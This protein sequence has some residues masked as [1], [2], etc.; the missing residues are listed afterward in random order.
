[1]VVED[2]YDSEYR[3]DIKPVPTLYGLEDTGSVI[4][5]GTVSKTLSPAL[6]IGYLV[7]PPA[8]ATV[9]A[10][11]KQL[12]D[13]H[14]PLL[15]QEAFAFLLESGGY[16]A[17]IRRIRR[18]NGERRAALLHALRSRFGETV[19]IEGADAGL[20]VVVWF[21]DLA[22]AMEAVLVAEAGR[23]GLGLHGVSPLYDADAPPGGTERPGPV[24]PGL[25]M[26]YAGLDTGRIARGID[27]LAD[28][29]A[30][31]RRG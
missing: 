14:A 13:R 3:Y 22:P 10:T 17:H 24:H 30:G 18:H 16:E 2:D 9:F 25:V 27:R 4:Y 6:R 20:H 11:A 26:G 15:A 5:L 1:M 7:L 21:R 28:L 23:H 29:V 31:L 12:T 8:L 19:T